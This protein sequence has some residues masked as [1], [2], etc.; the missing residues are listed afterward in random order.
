M[1][2]ISQFLLGILALLLILI[3]IGTVFPA[4]EP[5]QSTIKAPEGYLDYDWN[6]G[7]YIMPSDTDELMK[8]PYGRGYI[9]KDTFHII[10]K[11]KPLPYKKK[12]RSLDEVDNDL[13]RLRSETGY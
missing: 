5:A 10:P 1:K 12:K 3:F 8:N 13:Q 4:L 6:T 9:R 11:V 7:K 2:H